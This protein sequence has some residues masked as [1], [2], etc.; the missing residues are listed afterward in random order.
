MYWNARINPSAAKQ[1]VEKVMRGV[2]LSEAK[3]LSGTKSAERFFVA[4]TPT[5]AKPARAGDPGAL[6]RMTPTRFS[7]SRPNE[8]PSH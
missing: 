4:S 7:A 5:H 3:N 1:F 8:I 2:I 6:L